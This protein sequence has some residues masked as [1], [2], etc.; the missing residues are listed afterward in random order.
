[1]QRQ[2]QQAIDHRTPQ[3]EI[4]PVG[5]VDKDVGAQGRKQ[6]LEDRQ[7]HHQGAQHIETAE[8]SLAQHLVDN[9]LDQQ[10]NGQT[11]QLR[12]QRRR[13]NENQSAAVLAQQRC[14]PAPAKPTGGRG[15]H[16]PGQH[17]AGF[18]TESVLEILQRHALQ[19]QPRVPHH[20][21]FGLDREHDHRRTLQ[22]Q[23]CGGLEAT[24]IPTLH[25][26]QL[27]LQADQL[28]ETGK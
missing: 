23:Q 10:R 15:G 13:E 22:H 4:H 26:P 21:R 25:L 27:R 28:S 5:G 12:Q 9:L 6:T 3:R 14:E 11:K 19:T 7:H 24:E 1:M 2:C 17:K 16:T 18:L 20:S 8:I